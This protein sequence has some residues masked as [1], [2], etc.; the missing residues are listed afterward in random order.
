MAFNFSQCRSLI[1]QGILEGLALRADKIAAIEKV[2]NVE[3]PVNGVSLDLVPWHGALGVSLRLC[4]E[5]E[6]EIR[7][8]NVEWA[9]FDLVSNANCPVLQ[10]A[11][12]FVHQAYTS[13]NSNSMARE[14]AHLIFL[15]GAAALLDPS[16]AHL[17]VELGINAPT[18]R[19]DFLSPLFEYMVFDFDQTVRVN[20]C[21]L[22]CA[23]RVTAKW[24]PHLT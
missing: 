4:T 15:A 8:C 18:C 19:D 12:D 5:F 11:A 6:L 7:Y 16:V 21:E 24:L 3:F 22:V 9:Y 20:Y 2:P 1:L 23:N 10:R 17:L 13:E 14:M